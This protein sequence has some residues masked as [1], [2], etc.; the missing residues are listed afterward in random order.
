MPPEVR[1][2][3]RDILRETD[4]LENQAPRATRES[5]LKDEILK[6]AFVRSIEIIGEVA[7]KIP[8]DVR[9]KFPMVEWRKMTGTRDPLIH[10]YDEVDYAIVWDVAINKAPQVAAESTGVRLRD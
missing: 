8:E 7:K 9:G 3:L 2:C 1:E 10:D 6:R 4:F 5:F